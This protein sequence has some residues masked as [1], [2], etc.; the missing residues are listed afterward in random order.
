MGSQG[1]FGDSRK[2]D[3]ARIGGVLSMVKRV[4]PWP[5]VPARPRPDDQS[6]LQV[7]LPTGRFGDDRRPGHYWRPHQLRL[8]RAV[9]FTGRGQQP[10]ELSEGLARDCEM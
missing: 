3:R 4:P 5:T 7:G 9:R 1:W 2:P 6:H 8:L 10:S